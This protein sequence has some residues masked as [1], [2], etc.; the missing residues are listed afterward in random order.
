M[1]IAAPSAAAAGV[2][3]AAV[4]AAAALIAGCGT[5]APAAPG[6]AAEVTSS[7][8]P[9]LAT[10]VGTPSGSWAVA[11]MGGSAATHDNFW[12]LFVRPAGVSVW[13]LATPPGTPDNGGLVVAAGGPSVVTAFR[14]SQYLTYTPLT[15]TS[16]GG[17]A[18]ASTG[19]LDGVLANI[20]DA[21]TA[22]PGAQRLLALLAGGTVELAAAPYAS[23]KTI[24]TQRSIAATPAGRHCGLQ[25]LT[26]VSFT[27]TGLPLVAGTCSHPG[28]AGVFADTG[29]TWDAVGPALPGA[30]SRERVTVLRLIRTES[31]TV[32][33]LAASPGQAASSGQAASLLGA[34]S[35][36][37]GR[38]WTVSP[39]LPLGGA[40][41]ASASF[42]ATGTTAVITTTGRAD[43]ITAAG[44]QWRALPVPPPGTA[45]LAVG[46][47]GEIDAL[48]VHRATLTVWQA[49][50]GGSGWKLAQTISVPIQ[51]GTSG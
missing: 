13:K 21:L 16:N 40:A 26:A 43:V 27:L 37:N 50:A 5:T 19:P 10:S 47:G 29:G 11:V 3:A 45:T 8:A 34:W 20:P 12:Q 2:L 46:P 24:A 1:R 18:W 41:L 48:A 39:V 9:F 35:A 38:H 32:A 23:W 17:Q 49:P 42:G 30:L 33:V 14:P 15:A 31:Q 22:A 4:L 28:R 7:G 44:G 51:Y 36:D 6:P 25:A